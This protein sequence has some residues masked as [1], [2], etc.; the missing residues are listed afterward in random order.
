MP[1]VTLMP[2]LQRASHNML[3]ESDSIPTA[4]SFLRA[5][6]QPN[7]KCWHLHLHLQSPASPK[8]RIL[9][10]LHLFALLALL[11][12]Y[13]RCNQ[14]MDSGAGEICC[15]ICGDSV[16]EQAEGATEVY[17]STRTPQV[18]RGFPYSTLD[19][20]SMRF[21]RA[22]GFRMSSLLMSCPAESD[23]FSRRPV[24]TLYRKPQTELISRWR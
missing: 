20:R 23:F 3:I 16:S 10:A 14:C 8:L 4:W 6:N 15:S 19:T 21:C 7:S 12:S 18:H 24:A 1:T 9:H 22:G 5:S 2:A 17:I 11:S 13:V